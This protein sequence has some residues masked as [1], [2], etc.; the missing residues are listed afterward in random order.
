MSKVST[1]VV[2]PGV[3]SFVLD[4]RV[5]FTLA[6]LGTNSLEFM[7]SV[8]AFRSLAA[9]PSVKVPRS[10]GDKSMTDV[11]GKFEVVLLGTPLKVS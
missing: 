3:I 1:I 5:S 10:V 8:A 11:N 2:A 7:A 6:Y 9:D 4:G